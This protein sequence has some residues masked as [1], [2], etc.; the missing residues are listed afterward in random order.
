[1]SPRKSEVPEVYT[2]HKDLI[3][4][5]FAVFI[6]GGLAS[7][8]YVTRDSAD[9]TTT[10]LAAKIDKLSLDTAAEKAVVQYQLQEHDRRL[11]ALERP[12]PAERIR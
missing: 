5:L 11:L 3:Q 1:M 9:K 8:L 6:A 12:S 2:R 4:I 10:E 7:N